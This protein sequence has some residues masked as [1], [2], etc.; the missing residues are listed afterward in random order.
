MKIIRIC[1]ELAKS[2]I[3]R[4][5]KVWSLCPQERRFWKNHG[6]CPR[7]C[8]GINPCN[9]TLKRMPRCGTVKTGVFRPDADD[10]KG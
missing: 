1:E 6:L 7:E 9:S 8:C 5:R 4:V 2:L 10:T 3:S